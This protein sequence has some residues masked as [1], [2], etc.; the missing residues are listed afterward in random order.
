M[1]HTKLRTNRNGGKGELMGLVLG[2]SSWH[3]AEEMTLK[4]AVETVKVWN[5]H[6]ALVKI[7]KA[8]LQS[9]SNYKSQSTVGIHELRSIENLLKT[10]EE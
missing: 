3:F 7:A 10:L 2:N 6:D 4:D 5:A 1:E 8:R 9:L